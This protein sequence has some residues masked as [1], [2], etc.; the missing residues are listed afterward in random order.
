[1]QSHLFWNK[2]VEIEKKQ[3]NM[4]S[5][6]DIIYFG[7]VLTEAKVKPLSQGEHPGVETRI[8]VGR[9]RLVIRHPG[10]RQ[11]RTRTP[12]EHILTLAAPCVAKKK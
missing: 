9:G 3:K 6:F 7:S 11:E 5:L 1:M 12:M 8:F 10:E 4:C 2:G